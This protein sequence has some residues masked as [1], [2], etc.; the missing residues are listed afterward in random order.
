MG[1]TGWA[2]PWGGEFKIT[3]EVKFF[4]ICFLHR[5]SDA[6]HLRYPLVDRCCSELSL[7][8][9]ESATS[10]GRLRWQTVENHCP[11]ALKNNKASFGTI[12]KCTEKHKE[13][14]DLNFS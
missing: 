13:K 1:A 10:S 7:L 4:S 2:S 9:L 12:F 3:Q 5:D 11:Q 8:I 14:M 6:S